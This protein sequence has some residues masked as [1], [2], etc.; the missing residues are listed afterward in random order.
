MKN[1]KSLIVYAGNQNDTK[2][3]CANNF[4]GLFDL[5]LSLKQYK[6]DIS[7]LSETIFEKYNLIELLKCNLI[8]LYNDPQYD[9]IY[10]LNEE[11]VEIEKFSLLEKIERES[12]FILFSRYKKFINDYKTPLSLSHIPDD[13]KYTSLIRLVE[14]AI[15]N[16]DDYP[17][18]KLHRWLGFTQ[19]VL[20]A[21]GILNVNEERN[22][23]RPLL[24]LFH[25]NE[26]KSF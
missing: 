4:G 19:G 10:F 22:F 7:I 21:F 5:G 14:E 24:H 20:T 26:V 9:L 15:E 16:G 13:A 17:T 11:G 1:T 23:S 8:D 12:L 2:V 18:D 25:I 3:L 6:G